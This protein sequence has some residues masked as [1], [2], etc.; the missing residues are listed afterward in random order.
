[1]D[2]LNII[3][4]YWEEEFKNRNK[5]YKS[6]CAI[7]EWREDD[8]LKNL[9]AISFGKIPQIENLIDNFE[10]SYVK[11]L[12]S[13]RIKLLPDEK[14]DSKI[15]DYIYPLLL[16]GQKLLGYTLNFKEYGIFIGDDN[17]FN[18]L[19]SFWNLRASGVQLEFLSINYLERFTE[20]I[21]THIKKLDSIPNRNPNFDDW[22]NIYYDNLK[23]EDVKKIIKEL[24]SK[25]KI[26]LYHCSE[27][28][29]N[30]L[31][32]KPTSFYFNSDHVLA[33]IDKPYD[34]YKVTFNLPEKKFIKDKR[35]RTSSQIFAVTINP[36]TEFDYPEHTLKVPYIFELN[37][38]YS[39]KIKFRPWKLRVQKDGIGIIIR[40]MENS[41]NLHPISFQ[42]LFEQ[43]FNHLGLKVSSSQAGLIT[44]RII[45]KLGDIDGGRVFM[46]RGVRKLI[47]SLKSDDCI[48][49]NR[50][51][52]I[53][54]NNEQFR[55][56]ESLHIEHRDK[57][58]LN[59]DD[60]F[61]F[62]LKNDFFRAGLKLICDNCR[63]DSWL[64]LIEI[65]DIWV[66][67]Y[68]GY[69]NRTSLHIRNRGDWMFRK[70]GLFAKD[71]NQEG[72]IPVILTLL[73]F[74]RLFYGN[75][76]IYSPSLNIIAD[77]FRCEIDFCVLKRETEGS[78]KI[79]IGECKSENGKIDQKDIDNLIFICQKFQSAN[80]ECFPIFSKASNFYNNE[81][82][83]LF[84]KLDT[85]R[86]PFILLTNKELEPYF[87][88]YDI[89][90]IPQKY[91]SSFE[92]M[93]QNSF[94]TYL[95]ST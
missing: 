74:Y 81:E 33:N 59:T 10:E 80:I 38:F 31:N 93:V 28:S 19:I 79:G 60:V 12:K 94:H 44:K 41:L 52:E 7:I 58:N 3:Q 47:Q 78:I 1:M 24:K 69:K 14:I 6:N 87:P 61:D 27:I 49:R 15:I 4:Y 68:C 62:L 8:P 35:S 64:S 29:W 65:D 9:F 50:A 92:D 42:S 40:G 91:A 37:E 71:N 2:S 30:G 32:I 66:C 84:K 51:K 70:S 48:E 72:A 86:I 20:Y 63:L 11:G 75:D 88:Y 25:K 90:D 43:M 95:R 76:F 18:D 5:R 89:D 82:I 13:R 73:F 67:N 55:D 46:I 34:T 39:S 77:S 36:F 16:T 85:K 23:D 83:E 57:K 22:I 17:N 53:I 54:W 21:S 45:E 26:V 56:H